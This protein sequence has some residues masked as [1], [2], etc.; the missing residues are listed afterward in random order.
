MLLILRG[1]PGSGKTYLAENSEESKHQ[2]NMRIC[3]SCQLFKRRGDPAS[4]DASEMGIGEAYCRTRFLEAMEASVP[5]V[6]IDDIHSQLWEY[7]LYK[8]IACA[9]GYTC[10]VMELHC[11]EP[12]DILA[13]YQHCSTGQSLEHFQ[14]LAHGWKKDPDAVA[15]KPWFKDPPQNTTASK[16]L[17]GLIGPHSPLDL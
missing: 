17:L 1:L 6:V 4:V 8:H 10:Y 14:K 15:I 3:S 7:V 2:E 16:S 12:E 9:F 11:P 13:C 5:L